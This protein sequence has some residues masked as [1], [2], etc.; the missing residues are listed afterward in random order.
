MNFQTLNVLFYNKK[1]PNVIF[2]YFI[3]SKVT[4]LF[5]SLLVIFLSNFSNLKEMFYFRHI[6]FLT[7][8]RLTA[9]THPK[10]FDQKVMFFEKWLYSCYYFFWFSVIKK[11]SLIKMANLFFMF[12]LSMQDSLAVNYHP[13]LQL[14]TKFLETLNFAN[15]ISFISSFQKYLNT[16]T[17]TF[18]HKIFSKD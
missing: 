3:K 13:R 1:Q 17:Q 5:R 16:L 2:N 8:K 4:L 15:S 10:L 9:I 12:F 7:F 18:S 11:I 14:D 6:I